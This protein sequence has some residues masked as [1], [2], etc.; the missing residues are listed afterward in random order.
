M[1]IIGSLRVTIRS[2]LKSTARVVAENQEACRV[3]KGPPQTGPPGPLSATFLA[4]F[5]PPWTVIGRMIVAESC[6]PRP[7]SVPPSRFPSGTT[8]RSHF[9]S[10][11]SMMV[12]MLT[13]HEYIGPKLVR[14]DIPPQPARLRTNRL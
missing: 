12:H 3:D 1:P 8:R 2:C 14:N 11:G 13:C 10:Q 6:P 5:G 9:Y 7:I 4:V